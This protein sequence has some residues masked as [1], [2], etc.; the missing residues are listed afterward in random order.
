MTPYCPPAAAPIA[1]S[2][3]C[4]PSFLPGVLNLGPTLLSVAVSGL[5]RGDA[6]YD[7]ASHLERRTLRC[8]LYGA[9]KG[10]LG[11]ALRGIGIELV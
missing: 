11:L 3:D 7:Y 4:G 2:Q 5:R 10:L 6:S 1:I 9:P 8:D